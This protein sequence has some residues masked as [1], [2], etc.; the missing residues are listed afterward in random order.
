[1]IVSRKKL[2]WLAGL[3]KGR[4]LSYLGASWWAK[5]DHLVIVLKESILSRPP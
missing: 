5:N 2:P 4:I 3:S 1:M